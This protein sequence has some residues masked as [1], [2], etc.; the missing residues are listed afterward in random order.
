MVLGT[1]N[2]ISKIKGQGIFLSIR[3]ENI[4]MVS[5]VR[6]LG[7][8]MDEKLRFESHVI[9]VVRNC[10]YRLKLLYQIRSYLSQDVR[11]KL[12]DSL[13][14]SKFNYM[15]VVYGP[16]LLAHTQQLVQ[17]VQNACARFCFAIPPRTHV[18]P[19]LNNA[20]ILK[21]K[22]RRNLH[23]ATLLFGTIKHNNP[24]YLAEKLVWSR[25][26]KSRFT[27]NSV[28][29]LAIPRH[30]TNAFRGSF[31]FAASKCWNDLPPPFR[32]LKSVHTFRNKYK[33]Y[34]LVNQKSIL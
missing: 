26:V 31:K 29:S 25:D 34:L 28:S 17:R 14:L 5:E 15:D 6:N 10:F 20:N 3:G 32:S 24:F 21:M 4:E 8:L 30:R 22:F 1:R 13:V 16:R 27:R 2:Q 19:Y 7:L 9:G 12:C 11:I 33:V 18:T 23:L